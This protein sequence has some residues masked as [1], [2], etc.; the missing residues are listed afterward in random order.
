V[1]AT[2]V[3]DATEVD[4]LLGQ[5]VDAAIDD[6]LLELGV[7]HAESQQAADGLVAL[8]DGDRLAELVEFRGDRSPRCS[9]P[10]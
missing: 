1:V 8:E 4:A 6:P 7:G 5:D 9:N 3:D 10:E 2:H